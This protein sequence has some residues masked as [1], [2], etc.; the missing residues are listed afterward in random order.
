MGIPNSKPIDPYGRAIMDAGLDI[1]DRVVSRFHRA[2]LLLSSPTGN[3]QTNFSLKDYWLTG[4]T[5][6]IILPP[7]WNSPH[8]LEVKTKADD[9]VD[10]MRRG[11]RSYDEPH[12]LQLMC[13][14]LLT[15]I[16][17]TAL[18]FDKLGLD[19][20]TDGTIFYCSRDSP[21]KTAEFTIQYDEECVNKG[22]EKLNE[23]KQ[24]FL[25]EKLPERPKSWYWTLDP[26][27]YCELKKPCKEDDKY[28][29]HNLKL[30]HTIP[31]AKSVLSDY[32]YDKM[33]QEVLD[34][35]NS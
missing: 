33:R 4:H 28:N 11:A 10:E 24:A 13:Y 7:G 1:E 34:R 2:G 17:H 5:D 3:E 9:K 29:I 15:R 19:L 31:F 25:E 26:C 22:L 8:P 20:C 18:G 30:S 35:W 12:Y 6:A 32:D 14:M 23:W 16:F 21:L 27:R